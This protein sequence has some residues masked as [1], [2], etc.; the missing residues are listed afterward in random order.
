MNEN[1]KYVRSNF[2]VVIIIIY[3]WHIFKHVDI[4]RV[5]IVDIYQVL[6]TLEQFL[7]LGRAK[8]R[9][10]IWPAG[11][12]FWVAWPDLG[13]ILGGPTTFDWKIDQ[14]WAK[15]CHNYNVELI[16]GPIWA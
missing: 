3:F 16:S 2:Q 13:Y 12:G 9:P 10:E 4:Y 11:H 1:M 14:K 15:I 5:L 8:A 6:I 7:G